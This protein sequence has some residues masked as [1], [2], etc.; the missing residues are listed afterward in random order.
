MSPATKR[1]SSTAGGV[2]LK[3]VSFVARPA[4]LPEDIT[5][6]RSATTSDQDIQPCL[7][8]NFVFSTLAP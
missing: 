8:C 2:R 6:H 7:K 5:S 4:Q 1:T 3:Q